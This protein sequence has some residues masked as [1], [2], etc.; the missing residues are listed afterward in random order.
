MDGRGL[1]IDIECL[2]RKRLM[3][4]LQAAVPKEEGVD[5]G[6]TL[7]RCNTDV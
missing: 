7:V 5:F 2:T 1:G 6:G 4:K 3:V